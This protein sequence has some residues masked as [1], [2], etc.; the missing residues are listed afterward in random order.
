MPPIATSGL[1]VA[2]R[3]SRKPARPP[4][5]SGDAFDRVS[6]I[7]PKATTRTD[8]T[9]IYDY[10]Q[11]TYRFYKVLE[12]GKNGRILAAEIATGAI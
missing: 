3:A 1:V 8:D 4:V 11:H 10:S 2:A 7:G 6:K 5:G 12:K 9:L